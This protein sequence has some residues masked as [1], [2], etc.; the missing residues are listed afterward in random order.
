[1]IAFRARSALALAFTTLT[2]AGFHAGAHAHWKPD[3]PVTLV[4][5]YA[6][7]GG[8]D[9]QARAVAQELARIW[10]QPVIVDN[11]PGA[12]GMIGT[13]KAIAAKPDGLTL[14]VQIPSIT[15][16]KSVPSSKGFDP[17]SQLVPVS[18]F[19]SLPGVFV[20]NAKVPGRSLSDVVR[21][22]KAA[23]QPCSFGTTEN[24]ARLQAKMLGAES[25]IDNLIVVN[26]KGGGQ[27]IPDL[28]ANNV[29]MAI[30]G[31]TAALPHHKSG[32][33]RILAIM[34]K[35]RAQVAPD[36]PSAGEAG[37]P[38]LGA[39]TWYGLFAPKGTPTTIVEGIA[40]AVSEAVKAESVLKTFSSLGAEPI[41]NTP[42]EFTAMVRDESQRMDALAKR[43]PLE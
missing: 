19:S 25:G 34:G 40:S 9:V 11:S 27:L 33:L 13:R 5:P 14:L 21:N 36:V 10:G 31:I 1:M 4:V 42:V 43:F 32:S 20:T 16:L 3:R 8:N 6:P 23:A 2:I 24:V 37:F 18:A 38:S 30:M 17:V 7:G 15:V 41:G 35:K 28:V 22:C 29:N 12:D 26:Y 39:I